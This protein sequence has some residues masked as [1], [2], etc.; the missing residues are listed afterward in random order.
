MTRALFRIFF[1]R[2]FLIYLVFGGSAAVVNLLCGYLFYTYTSLP[3]IIAVFL[4]ASCGLLV[5]F[6]LNYSFNFLYRGRPLLSQ[7]ATFV[8]VAMTGTVLTSL[9]AAMLLF[10]FETLSVKIDFLFVTPKF[11]AQFFAVGLVTFYSFAGHKYLS[12][13]EGIIPRCKILLKRGKNA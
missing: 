7:L 5:N 9:I 12:F 10:L 8:C 11:V 1:S 3:Y 4:A 13:N 6:L 2:Q